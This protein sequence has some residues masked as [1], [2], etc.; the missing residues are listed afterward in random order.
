MADV[1]ANTFAVSGNSGPEC[2]VAVMSQAIDDLAPRRPVVPTSVYQDKSLSCSHGWV[3]SRL[4]RPY[5]GQ[6][7]L[8]PWVDVAAAPFATATNSAAV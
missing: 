7:V 1:L 3:N 5:S 6:T 4:R 8:T 2:L